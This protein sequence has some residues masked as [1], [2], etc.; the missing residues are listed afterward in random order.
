MLEFISRRH[1]IAAS[2]LAFVLAGCGGG[3]S[4]NVPPPITRVVALGDSNIDNGNL[5]RLSGGVF[6]AAPNWQGRN[7]NGPNV[8]EYLA[9][10]LNATLD[11]Y[12][13][14]GATT[15]QGNI[16]PD[17][18]VPGVILSR[19]GVAGQVAD[20][21]KAGA[22]FTESDLVVLWA[23]SNDIYGVQRADRATLDQRIATAAG[24]IQSA[25]DKL[26]V[27]GARRFLVANRTPREALG[28][29]NDLNGVDLNKA[30]D[31]A[32][33]QAR[34]KTGADVRLYDAYGAIADM[35]K[36][37][38]TY[39]F[40]EVNTLC[41]NV[42]ACANDPYAGGLPVANTYVNWDGAHK[43]TRVHQLMAEQITQ[44]L[45]N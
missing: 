40:K 10:G 29:E 28:T 15:G 26:G 35:M 5:L 44:M 16:V 9:K 6:P 14:S 18:T 7:S 21:E 2:L 25:I 11:D 43:T 22:H 23:G 45:K 12:A 3:S 20:L 30:I 31:A 33:A 1:A 27:L 39:G 4:D 34:S 32:V 42:P 13:V 37:P 19:T 36:N 8:V 38:G 17:N 41:W 24:N